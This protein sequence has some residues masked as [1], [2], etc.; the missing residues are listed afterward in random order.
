[1]LD[2]IVKFAAANQIFVGLMGAASVGTAA[3]TLRALPRLLQ[4]M[5][6]W[7][8]SVEI[9]IFNTDSFFGPLA[10]WL[11]KH[12]H[13]QKVRTLR[14]I[15]IKVLDSDHQSW[16]MA[17]GEGWHWFR[18]DG[19]WYWY[20]RSIDREN[21]RGNFTRESL[22]IRTWGRRQDSLYKILNL[23]ND[24]QKAISGVEVRVFS[25]G[26]WQKIGYKSA[27][28]VSSILSGDGAANKLLKDARWFL[29][30]SNWYADRGIPYRRG[31]LFYGEPGTGKT[32]LAHVLASELDIPLY[33]LPLGSVKDDDDLNE[34]F[35]Q[36]KPRS[37][38]LIEDIDVARASME[39][40]KESESGSDDGEKKS[41]SGITLSGLLNVI[42][43]I[44]ASDGRILIMTTNHPD[45][46]DAALV[47][48]GRVDVRLSFGKV[49]KEDALPMIQRF[50][51]DI[52]NIDLGIQ[53][54]ATP[55]T[56]QTAL[57]SLAGQQ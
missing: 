25:G 27:R 47:R 5:A 12:P 18:H 30:S 37:I 6:R 34:A 10:D 21:S 55:A 36:V 26:Y 51:F 19:R 38:L 44:V 46:L 49:S 53:W 22:V 31:Y 48:P 24:S 57:L 11:M 50:G 14:A 4:D 9:L 52:A 40:S 28:R 32:S 16:S 54:P 33:F 45:N 15:D 13:T 2:D 43:G 3:Y 41:R 39:R 35:L 56:I 8:F 7:L 29:L 42:D 17:P 1:M 20:C 23:V